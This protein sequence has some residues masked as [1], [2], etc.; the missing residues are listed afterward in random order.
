MTNQMCLNIVTFLSTIELFQPE[1]FRIAANIFS[2]TYFFDF[3]TCF[4]R[5]TATGLSCD[6]FVVGYLTTLTVYVVNSVL[7]L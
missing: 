7:D 2:F 6:K 1:N 5:Q 4:F 3:P